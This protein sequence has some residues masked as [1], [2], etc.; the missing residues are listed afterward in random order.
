MMKGFS[1][2]KY[3]PRAL[4]FLHWGLQLMELFQG[5]NQ[6]TNVLIADNIFIP[7]ELQR[8]VSNSRRTGDLSDPCLDDL[9]TKELA[10]WLSSKWTHGESLRVILITSLQLQTT[11]YTNIQLL[12]TL[13]VHINLIKW[14]L[15]LEA[16]VSTAVVMEGLSIELQMNHRRRFCNYGEG[17]YQGMYQ[18]LQDV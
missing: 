10:S 4:F 8:T 14:I 13:A 2:V 12:N 1:E 9:D 7:A 18:G 6:K 17:S 5:M 3:E 16:Q 11:N 15:Y